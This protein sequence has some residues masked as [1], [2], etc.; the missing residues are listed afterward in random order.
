M[1]GSNKRESGKTPE[2]KIFLKV[3]QP[4][5]PIISVTE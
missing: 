2:D 3:R 5:G 1:L 4:R